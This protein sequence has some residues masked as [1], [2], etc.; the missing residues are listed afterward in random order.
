MKKLKKL[1]NLDEYIHS[2]RLLDD[3]GITCSPWNKGQHDYGNKVQMNITE[4]H[5]LQHIIENPGLVIS[6]ISRYWGFTLCAASKIA[7]SLES[8]GLIKKEKKEGNQKNLYLIPTELGLECNKSHREYDKEYYSA[9]IE[10][11]SSLYSEKELDIFFRVM[12]S[13]IT[14]GRQVMKGRGLLNNIDEDDRG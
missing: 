7:S 5:T 4:A 11:L 10:R 2:F 3:Y 13:Y 6:D 14:C 12:P 9:L 8:K 1:K